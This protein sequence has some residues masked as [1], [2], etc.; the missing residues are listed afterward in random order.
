MRI[1][2]ADRSTISR[3]NNSQGHILED[4]IMGAARRY[5][6]QGRLVIHKESEPFRMVKYLNRGRG[7]AEVQFQ[8]KAQPDFIGCLQ[9]GRLIAI[10]A[11]YTQTDRIKQGAVTEAQ[12]A[13]LKKYHEAG[14]LAFVACGIGTGFDLKYF[15]VPWDTWEAMQDIWGHKYATA[16]ELADYEVKADMVIYFMD[17]IEPGGRVEDTC[18]ITWKE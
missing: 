5:E 17:Y 3:V 18:P 14:A 9:G 13:V 6:Q 16:Q 4:M 12:G 10:E 15:M 11:K 2:M 1:N 7:R 8:Q